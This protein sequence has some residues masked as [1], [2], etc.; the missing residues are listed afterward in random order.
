MFK[1]I[2]FD[3][4]GTLLKIDMNEFLQYYFRTMAEM[5][6]QSGYKKHRQLVE[7]VF[8]STGVMIANRD[9]LATN[10]D[11]FMNDFFS[12]WPHPRADFEPFFDHFYRE[13]FPRLRPLCQPVAGV[14][15][16]MQ[17]LAQKKVK[18]AV[19]TN[20]VF[21]LTALEQ[22]I[23]WAGLNPAAFHLITSFEVMHFCKPHLEYYQEICDKLQVQPEDCLMVGNDIGED[24]V[25][26]KLGMKTYLV[27][28]HLIDPGG[29]GLKPDW[30]GMMCDFLPFAAR[31]CL[32]AG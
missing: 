14:P 10:E 23:A 1:A 20:A 5:A 11:V 19:A 13:G 25:A 4:D 12:F 8:K 6:A 16:L 28:D 29:T 26:Q 15:E 24:M 21:P 27:E 2:L 18:I 32:E 17:A 22:R 31:F 3:L 9:P 7:Q 30:R